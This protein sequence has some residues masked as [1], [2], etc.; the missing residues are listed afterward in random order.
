MFKFD[1]SSCDDYPKAG[2][3]NVGTGGSSGSSSSSGT[4]GTGGSTPASC[5][6][7]E[8]TMTVE[9]TCGVFVSSTL[10]DD[11]NGGTKDKP[12]KTLGAAITAAN[13]KPVYACG[14]AFK[15]AVAISAGA[16]VYGAVDCANGWAYDAA[17]KT[18]LTAEVDQIPLTI[19][20][21]TTNAQ[22]YDFAITA[23]SA[24]KDGGSSIGT[25]VAQATASFTRCEITAGDGKAGKAGTAFDTSAASGTIGDTGKNACVADQ[26]F[27]GKSVT[28]A[29]GNPDSVSGSGGIGDILTG[30]SGNPG[31]PGTKMNG[32]VGE[33]GATCS[34]GGKGDDGIAGNP[35]LG[36]TTMGTLSANG[37]TG[38]GGPD[39]NPGAPGQGG[40]GGGGAKGGTG[41]GKCPTTPPNITGGA[42]GGSGGS[43]GCGGAG[44]K[45]GNAGGA[46][47]ALV[48]VNGTLL[49][50]NVTLKA[51]VGGKGGDGAPGQ[52]GGNG[53]DPGP[54]G[55]A[56]A[57]YANLSDACPGGKGG[58]G[59]FGGKGG[60]GRGGHSIGI[61][62]TGK[63]PPASSDTTWK[64]T[65]GTPGNGGLGDNAGGNMG[66]GAAGVAIELQQ[67]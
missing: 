26:S 27:G 63:A 19:T 54:A 51:G 67:F 34:G 32:G 33:T 13:G 40:G 10:G 28:N 2:C 60:G 35:A 66:D 9:D 5:I 3:P 50:S 21:Q 53:G 25:L 17:K 15:E 41:T 55:K 61:A 30:G 14:E 48:S 22:I 31:L 11:A 58:A 42:S 52:S 38:A 43:G 7:S 8:N 44:G 45:G 23:A 36:A 4:G 49:L 24:D 46:S 16:T 65:V 62:Y 6:P 18:Q 59:G 47:F 1:E 64:A 57:T 20:S 37:Y 12:F 39:G 29:C 56:T